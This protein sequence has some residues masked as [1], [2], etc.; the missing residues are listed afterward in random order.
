MRASTLSFE[1]CKGIMLNDNN[2]VWGML[3]DGMK[4]CLY[5]NTVLY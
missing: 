2:R 1:I 4:G 5:G 3:N